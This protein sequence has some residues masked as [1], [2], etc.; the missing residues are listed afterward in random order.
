MR[1]KEA[2]ASIVWVGIRVRV[3]MVNAMIPNPF[4][5]TILQRSCLQ[6]QQYVIQ[7]T[8]DFVAFMSPISMCASRNPERMYKA[9][10]EACN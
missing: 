5:H 4:N 2:T 7:W 1:E 10:C 9:V 8:S 6:K 3:F